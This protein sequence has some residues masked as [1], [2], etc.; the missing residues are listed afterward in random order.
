MSLPPHPFARP[1][2]LIA[3][4]L[5]YLSAPMASA[6]LTLT[7]DTYHQ[8]VTFTVD[9]GSAI[10]FKNFGSTGGRYTFSMAT[11]PPPTDPYSIYFAETVKVKSTGGTGSWGFS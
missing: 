3:M 1:A 11:M 5:G 9:G 2:F 7:I 10:S 6:A 4:V 8:K